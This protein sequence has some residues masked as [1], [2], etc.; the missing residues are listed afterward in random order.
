MVVV[1]EEAATFTCHILLLV[2]LQCMGNYQIFL[3]GNIAKSRSTLTFEDI[4]KHRIFAKEINFFLSPGVDLNDSSQ[5][6]HRE[7]EDCDDGAKKLCLQGG[8]SGKAQTPKSTVGNSL[9]TSLVSQPSSR[10]SSAL[11][12]SPKTTDSHLCTEPACGQSTFL[13]LSSIFKPTQSSCASLSPK[14]CIKRRPSMGAQ[15]AY[16]NSTQNHTVKLIELRSPSKPGEGSLRKRGEDK[17]DKSSSLSS[18]EVPQRNTGSHHS[19]GR[20]HRSSSDLP[21]KTLNRGNQAEESRK[22]DSSTPRSASKL[23]QSCRKAERNKTGRPRRPVAI[24]YDIDELFTPDPMTYVVSPAHKT[25]KPKID[26]GTI[27]SPTSESSCLSSS[28]TPVTG[29]L[30]RKT[31]NL[32]V[33]GSPHARDTKVPARHPQVSFPTVALQRVKLENLRSICSNDSELKNSP[34]TSS[35]RQLKD[36]SVKSDEKRT[37]LLPN[38]VRPCALETGTAASEQT[39][40]PHCSQSPLLERQASEGSRRQLNEEDPIDVELDLGLSFALDLDLT[41]SSHSSEDEQ[42]LSLQE[43]ME[44]VTKPPDTP[45]K[46]AFSEPSTPG[47]RSCQSKTVSSIWLVFIVHKIRNDMII[48][49]Q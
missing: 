23:S 20:T 8:N 49:D 44:R 24:S 17:M 7:F 45:D 30:C 35:G 4:S 12:L 47:H 14:P 5:K 28:S 38:N 46:G 6:R 11:E 13:E 34:I 16:I 21:V 29:S 10:H 18:S 48:K 36:E 26:E 19:S 33:T 37:S 42:L 15:Q 1:T 2:R 41:Q 22:S 27:K 40:T 43:M 39:S 31:Q 25:A 9:S 32:S 3:H